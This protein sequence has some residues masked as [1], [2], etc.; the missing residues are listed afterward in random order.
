MAKDPSRSEGMVINDDETV[1]FS[2][3]ISAVGKVQSGATGRA[4]HFDG[5]RGGSSAPAYIK[6]ES[7]NGTAQYLFVEDDGTVKRHTAIPTQNSDGSEVGA[8][9]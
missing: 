2:Q 1:D 4:G 8:Q 3:S 7:A 5:V 9:T 6:L